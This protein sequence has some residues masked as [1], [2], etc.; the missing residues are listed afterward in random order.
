M[1]SHKIQEGNIRNWDTMIDTN[2]KGL[3]YVTRTFLPSMVKRNRDHII[4]I[5]SVAGHDTYPTGNVYCATKFAT[6]AITK[7]LR[8]DLSALQFE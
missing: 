1:D 3:L 6:R 2:V 5:G 7:S 8:L 4:N